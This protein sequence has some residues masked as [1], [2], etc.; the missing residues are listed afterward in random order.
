MIVV[1]VYNGIYNREKVFSQ[2]HTPHLQTKNNEKPHPK[3]HLLKLITIVQKNRSKHMQRWVP[4]LGMIHQRQMIQLTKHEL[5]ELFCW[6]PLFR[7]LQK[8][9]NVSN[10]VDRLVA[11]VVV[12]LISCKF[13]DDQQDLSDASEV[14]VHKMIVNDEL[15]TFESLKIIF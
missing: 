12:F 6:L 1:G 2:N 8:I 13:L 9:C 11:Y 15:N 3:N 5:P 14:E 7:F 10:H 4:Y